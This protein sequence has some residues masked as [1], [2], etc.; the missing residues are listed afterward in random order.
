MSQFRQ[1]VRSLFQTP[2]FALTA[3]LTI[4]LGIGANTAVYAVVHAVL[5]EPLPF[6][7]PESLVQIWETHPELHNLQVSVPD[8][9]DWKRS[10]KTLD[11]AAYTF[12]AINKATLVGQG[13]PLAIQST[14][15]SWELFPLLG[16]RPILGRLYDAADDKGKQP[17][18]LISEQLWRRKFSADRN[19]IGRRL[20]LGATSFTIV[21][22]LP[23]RNS[24]PIWADTWV[25]FSLMGSDLYSERKFHPLEVVGRLKPNVP[26]RQAEVESESVASRLSTAYPATNGKIGAF[27]VPLMDAIIG[28]VRPA[29]TAV[30]VGVGLVLLIACANLT[31][32]MMSRALHRRREIAVRLALGAS[33]LAAFWMFLLETSILAITGGL[34]GVLAAD[35]ALPIIQHLALGQM[36]RLEAL[37]LNRP[38]LLFGLIASLIVAFVFALPSFVLFRSN[39]ND[40]LSSANTRI[41]ARQSW[42]DPVMTA[43]EVALSAAVLVGAILLVRSFSLTL[44]TPPGFQHDHVLAV[45]SPLVAGDWN[46]SDA[47]FRNRIAP[48]LQK[49]PGVREVAAVNSVPMS[50][51]PTEHSRFATRF[52]IAG[53][54]FEPGRFPTGQMRWCTAN[55]FR[56]LGIPLV[57]GRLLTES[58]NGQPRYLINE[59][60]ARLFFPHSDAVGQK[61]LLG[62]VT[63]NPVSAEIVGVVG[64]VREFGLTS[65][66]EPSMYF[67]SISPE[68]ELVMKTTTTDAAMRSSISTAMRQLNP[69]QAIGPVRTLDSYIA[70]SLAR[71]RFVLALVSTFAALALC[72]CGV[73]VYGV[74]S[75]SVIRRMR[76]FGIRAA[77]GALRRDLL[78]QVINESLA[79]IVPG[80]LGGIAIFA[81]CSQVMRSLLYQVSPKDP[82]SSAAAAVS[83]LL[84]CLISVAIPALRAAQV[85]PAIILREQ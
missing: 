49:I 64:D 85:D 63:P 46:K 9:L 21:G 84:L 17:V 56:V 71:Q 2:A 39:L 50:L 4:A 69:Q 77:V 59:T 36:P 40:A 51:G 48:E 78:R 60:F 58:D 53:K 81:L 43:A 47:L 74:F 44:Q 5:L 6:R 23:R 1:S 82:L 8:Y 26:L 14:N 25:P 18:I 42:L 73:G 30:W 20:Q 35:V 15:A 27:T 52:G 55:Y 37:Q 61:I 19:A 16:I 13:E 45:H 28:E 7:Q 70:G 66:P 67:V 54:R 41:S 29:L 80:L 24:F 83:I 3:A 38:V 12:Q 22:V 65:Q 34:L 33:R 10:F 62:I 76:E 68:I 11:I 75:Y 79:V 57:K 31:H 72:L 32:L